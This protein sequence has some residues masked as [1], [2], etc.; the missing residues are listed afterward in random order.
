LQTKPQSAIRE[1]QAAWVRFQGL[2]PFYSLP[3]ANAHQGTLLPDRGFTDTLER[4]NKAVTQPLYWTQGLVI[5]GV[6]F[7]L[8]ALS[9]NLLVM[10]AALPLF[11]YLYLITSSWE[12]REHAFHLCYF[13]D[14]LSHKRWQRLHAALMML[15]ETDNIWYIC[16][17]H[18]H[19]DWKR[20]AGMTTR[21]LRQPAYLGRRSPFGLMV[22]ITPS[23]LQEV[24]TLKT[25]RGHTL[26]FLPDK[27]YLFESKHYRA[28]EYG[29]IKVIC[30]AEEYPEE[31]LLP[32]D[33]IVSRVTWKYVNR[34]GS[35]DR[36]FR[37]TDNY[38]VH[39]VQYGCV[40]FEFA[41]G[42]VFEFLT[43]SYESA[44]RFVTGWHKAVSTTQPSASSSQQQQRR[45]TQ[46]GPPPSY[47]S[48]D[49]LTDCCKV[50]NLRPNCTREEAARKYRELARSCHPDRP[51][52]LSPTDRQ[53]A[54]RRM[55]EINEAYT[56]L[57]RLK[58]W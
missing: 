38:R 19:G 21:V 33:A 26:C 17:R 13:L 55:Q 28:Y 53:A 8:L 48:G 43:S 20:N 37:S 56:Q 34:D 49:A 12:R 29:Q 16:G 18:Y 10:L 14:D 57:K 30:R 9:I 41:D 7:L 11:V 31:G 51:A 25:N 44:K 6:L 50:L 23:Q 35:P 45:H 27:L 15:L 54:T 5:I 46:S 1:T 4:L 52:H 36:R 2:T 32:K 42:A 47:G 39:I 3:L 24:F 22:H 40:R 58:G